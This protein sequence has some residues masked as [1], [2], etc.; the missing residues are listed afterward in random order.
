[1][2]THKYRDDSNFP[3]SRENLKVH[4]PEDANLL[5]DTNAHIGQE[6]RKSLEPKILHDTRSAN[7]NMR[8][9]PY[10]LIVVSLYTTL[11]VAAWALLCILCERPLTAKSYDVPE[12][13]DSISAPQRF[14]TNKNWF[15]A[16]KIL[17]AIT[18]TLIIPLTSTV[19]AGAAVAYIQR[20][21]QRSGFTMKRL[22]TIADP[23]WTNP[24]LLF[25]ILRP[26]GWKHHGSSFLVFA[27]FL[28]TIGICWSQKIMQN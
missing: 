25:D 9:R 13:I 12:N 21:G 27:I 2:F 17:L 18:N 7:I 20:M 23:G 10:M 11:T 19:C 8:Q 15:R 28:I 3:T 5:D 1:M 26:S 16:T 6:Y 24:Q 4:E 22:I 14:L